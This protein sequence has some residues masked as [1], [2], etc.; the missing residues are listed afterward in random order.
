MSRARERCQVDDE[1]SLMTPFRHKGY[2]EYSFPNPN[3]CWHLTYLYK[4]SQGIWLIGR[5]RVEEKKTKQLCRRKHGCSSNGSTYTKTIAWMN[6]FSTLE[7]I[8]WDISCQDGGT[9]RKPTLSSTYPSN[10]RYTFIA[11]FKDRRR[12]T[13]ISAIIWDSRTRA[14]LFRGSHTNHIVEWNQLHAK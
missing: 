8:S 7:N 9:G 6:F 4:V 5:R 10:F 3:L 12:S 14:F 1:S 13:K 2:S 11:L